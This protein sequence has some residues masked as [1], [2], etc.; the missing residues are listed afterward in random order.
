MATLERWCTSPTYGGWCWWHFPPAS[1]GGRSEHLAQCGLLKAHGLMVAADTGETG[2][3]PM[4][5]LGETPEQATPS[6]L[7]P[8]LQS[9]RST[10]TPCHQPNRTQAPGLWQPL[11]SPMASVSPL[12]HRGLLMPCQAPPSLVVLPINTDR[13]LL[14]ARPHCSEHVWRKAHF[15]PGP[16]ALPLPSSRVFSDSASPRSFLLLGAPNLSPQPHHT[17]T[18]AHLSSDS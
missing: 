11:L 6:C 13:A 16:P 9:A 14:W 4:G 17:H 5:F 1:L 2:L 18:C 12:C 7:C 10:Q 3:F 15:S 8:R